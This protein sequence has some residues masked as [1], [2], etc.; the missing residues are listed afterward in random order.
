MTMPN[1]TLV[2]QYLM[3]TVQ[4]EL[5]TF[6]RVTTVFHAQ[7]FRICAAYDEVDKL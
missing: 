5:V 2:S 4:L 3:F 1:H 7:D 6:I